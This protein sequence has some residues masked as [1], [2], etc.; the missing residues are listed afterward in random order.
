VRSLSSPSL[1]KTGSCGSIF[2]VVY[3]LKGCICC[4]GCKRLAIL[5]L[6]PL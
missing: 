4:K 5:Q 3:S 2:I 6:Q 1:S